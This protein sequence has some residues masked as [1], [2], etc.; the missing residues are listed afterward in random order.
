VVAAERLWLREPSRVSDVRRRTARVLM[1]AVTI[2]VIAVAMFVGP[3]VT[4][5]DQ[6]HVAVVAAMRDGSD[7]YGL[8]GG[9]V[10]AGAFAGRLIPLPTLAL[11]ETTFGPLGLTMLLCGVLAGILLVAWERLDDVFADVHG[12][13]IGIVMLMGGATAGALL[14]IAEPHAGWCALL[15]AWSLLLRR[16]ERW[17]EA[18]AIA[19]AAATIDPAA[20]VVALVMGGIAWHDGMRREAAGWL[21]AIAVAGATWATHRVALAGLALGAIGDGARVAP[22][23]FIVAASLPGV[24]PWLAAAVLILAIAGWG[25]VRGDLAQRVIALAIAGP[26]VAQAPGM[27][28]AATLS[29]VLLPVGL[30]FVAEGAALLIPAA[31]NRRRI[32]VTRVAR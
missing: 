13:V 21:L 7:F 30:M 27:Q 15:A 10:P 24:A 29:I 25:I 12:R 17:I 8:I 19:C 16:R 20:G 32:T 26:L 6:D 23:D 14:V 11:V 18:A 1:A 5:G 22:L 3:S 9:I 2:A 31:S 4:L 28:S